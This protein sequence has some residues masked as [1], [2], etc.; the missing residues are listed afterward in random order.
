M[1][2]DGPVLPAIRSED[3][4]ASKGMDA[5]AHATETQGLVAAG[6]APRPT[7]TPQLPAIRRVCPAQ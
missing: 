2:R 6:P 7:V 4:S 1:A 5:D 3:Q